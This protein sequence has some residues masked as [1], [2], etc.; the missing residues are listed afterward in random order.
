MTPPLVLIVLG[1]GCLAFALGC[2]GA[3]VVLTWHDK[4]SQ[5]TKI[6]VPKSYSRWDKPRTFKSKNH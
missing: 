4:P 6:K 5:T 1:V 2:A 3:V